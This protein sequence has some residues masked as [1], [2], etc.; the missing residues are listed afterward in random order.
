MRSTGGTVTEAV[1]YAFDLLDLDGEDL[2][3]MPVLKE[4]FNWL[5]YDCHAPW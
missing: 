3:A 1:M 5:L 2:R 4:H